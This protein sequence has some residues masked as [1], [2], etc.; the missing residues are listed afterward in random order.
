MD[1]VPRQPGK[2]GAC[3]A[4]HVLGRNHRTIWEA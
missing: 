1:D 3:R 4:R 2:A